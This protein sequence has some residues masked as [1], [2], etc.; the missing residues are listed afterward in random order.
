MLYGQIITIKSHRHG[1]IN[2]FSYKIQNYVAAEWDTRQTITIDAQRQI[3]IITIIPR[4]F[5]FVFFC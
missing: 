5:N 3:F 2:I 1:I 4:I